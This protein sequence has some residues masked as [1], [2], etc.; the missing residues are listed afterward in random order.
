M[1]VEDRRLTF[2][3]FICPL[4][5]INMNVRFP[6]QLNVPFLLWLVPASRCGT[7]RLINGC[8]GDRRKWLNVGMNGISSTRQVHWNFQ[9]PNWPTITP[10]TRYLRQV[11][12][13]VLQPPPHTISE[14]DSLHLICS[15]VG[16]RPSKRT[17]GWLKIEIL[18]R[19]WS[20]DYPFPLCPV[21]HSH[22]MITPRAT[23]SDS[24]W[25][26]LEWYRSRD[27]IIDHVTQ[28]SLTWLN[29]RSRDY[30]TCPRHFQGP[31][32]TSFIRT[33]DSSPGSYRS[34]RNDPNADPN[35]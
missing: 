14:N 11:V 12:Y 21:S 18:R 8:D 29:Y 35:R 23:A 20:R 27:S 9:N 16:R 13:F 26:W 1:S 17:R 34:S 22:S 15:T 2:A 5:R 25:L 7:M 3:L 28:L 4:C 33:I 19:T 31:P 24:R 30:T 6:S 32:K 10:T